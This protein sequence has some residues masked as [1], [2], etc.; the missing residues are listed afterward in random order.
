VSSI[1]G[2]SGYL[3]LVDAP[4]VYSE[5]TLYNEDMSVY[6]EFT[7]YNTHSIHCIDTDLTETCFGLTSL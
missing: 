4:S 5:F 1:C 3:C 7:L 6:S 2:P